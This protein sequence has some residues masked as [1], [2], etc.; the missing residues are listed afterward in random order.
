MPGSKESRGVQAKEPSL[1]VHINFSLSFYP[2]CFFLSAEQVYELE[3]TCC[4]NCVDR[5]EIIPRSLQETDG[6]VAILVTRVPGQV[7]GFTKGDLEVAVC[8]GD[9]SK[10]L[11]DHVEYSG[12]P[13]GGRHVGWLFCFFFFFFFVSTASVH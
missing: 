10:G 1:P 9:A 3:H 4:G 5:L 2:L 11:G 7:K 6:N 13:R 12:G 8:E